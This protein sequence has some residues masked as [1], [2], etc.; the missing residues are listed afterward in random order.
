[1]N[2][3]MKFLILGMLFWIFTLIGA[4]NLII[5]ISS[6]TKFILFGREYAWERFPYLFIAVVVF[7]F[8][9]ALIKRKLNRLE[10]A[11]QESASPTADDPSNL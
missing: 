3:G 4:G 10:G 1:M 8:I 11:M 9:G 6:I 5:M 7:L 2:R